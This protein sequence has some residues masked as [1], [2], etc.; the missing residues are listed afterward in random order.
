MKNY[1]SFLVLSLFA[2]CAVLLLLLLSSAGTT[3]ADIGDTQLLMAFNAGYHEVVESGE[4]DT[5]MEKWNV[6]GLRCDQC[7]PESSSMNEWPENPEGLFRTI[8]IQSK[9]IAFGHNINGFP[10]F[11]NGSAGLEDD[12]AEAVVQRIGAHYNV[13]DLRKKWVAPLIDPKGY[14]ESLYQNLNTLGSDLLLSNIAISPQRRQV[15]EFSCPYIYVYSA[16][17]RS[18][19]DPQL[20]LTTP[21]S[22]NA[23]GVKVA[24]HKG[25]VY[26]PFAATNLTKATVII[27]DTLAQALSMVADEEVHVAITGEAFVVALQ[28][29][30]TSLEGN[31]LHN[32][33]LYTFG[34]PYAMAAAA[35]KEDADESSDASSIAKSIIMLVAV[36]ASA[37]ILALVA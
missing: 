33:T 18:G 7:L 13:P 11:W 1:F 21:E 30:F 36:V 17:V 35:R 4:Y 19:L 31:T 9:V 29:T 3:N 34:E 8:L 10:P 25:S 37:L 32:A 24:I 12:L 6:G 14:F 15:V 26:E 20:T 2:F 22:L 28:P 27:R 23:P 16:I 5:I